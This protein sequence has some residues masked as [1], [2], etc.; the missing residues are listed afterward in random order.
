MNKISDKE[1]L[2]LQRE[3]FYRIFETP[4]QRFLR[5]LA[6]FDVNPYSEKP[7]K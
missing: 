6:K 2:R 1:K 7:R 3:L 5:E 4:M